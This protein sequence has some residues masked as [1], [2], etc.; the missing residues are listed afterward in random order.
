MIIRRERRP[1]AERLVRILRAMRHRGAAVVAGEFAGG[2]AQ[3]RDRTA[4]RIA[5]DTIE[6][7]A[8][9]ERQPAH[10]SAHRFALHLERTGRHMRVAYLTGALELDG[11]DH[12]TVGQDAALAAR[13]FE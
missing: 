1:Q 10:R 6:I 8:R 3:P 13:A 7:E 2:E 12:R 9:L 4:E 5:V 11:A